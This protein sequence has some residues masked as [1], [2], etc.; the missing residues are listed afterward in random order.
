ML[1]KVPEV[2]RGLGKAGQAETPTDPARCPCFE[3]VVQL[4]PP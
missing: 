3:T 2:Q 1:R 4:K